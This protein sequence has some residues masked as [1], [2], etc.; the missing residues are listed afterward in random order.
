MAS[1]I[2]CFLLL[3][4]PLLL[5]A[6]HTFHTPRL[7]DGGA[8]G[9]GEGSSSA[10]LPPPSTPRLSRTSAQPRPTPLA[11]PGGPDPATTNFLDGIVDFFKEYM[12]L[13]SV[14]GSLAFLLLFIVCTALIVRQKHKASAYYPSSFPKKKYVHPSD[15]AGGGRAFSEV[16]EKPPAAQPQE[17]LDASCQLQADILAATQNL[18]SPA[19]GPSADGD[20]VL[21][22]ERP[23]TTPHGGDKDPDGAGRGTREVE[24]EKKAKGEPQGEPREEGEEEEEEEETAPAALLGAGSPEEECPEAAPVVAVAEEVGAKAELPP[25]APGEACACSSRP[26]EA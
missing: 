11:G 1:R 21:M 6:A 9:E 5:R 17:P 24:G 26:P 23:P 18:R 13:I 16:P 20:G 25:E 19:R 22:E 10:S 3:L 15:K 4:L 8:S 14:V 7:E 12:L 2:P